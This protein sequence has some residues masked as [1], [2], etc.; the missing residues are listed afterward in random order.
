VNP[1]TPIGEGI[2]ASCKPRRFEQGIGLPELRV[3]QSKRPAF[4]LDLSAQLL[5][6]SSTEGSALGKLPLGNLEPSFSRAARLGQHA[7]FLL[8]KATAHPL[9]R[10]KR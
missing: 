1:R 6:T 5:S 10:R 4:Q 7:T 8:E 9:L 3:N 2:R